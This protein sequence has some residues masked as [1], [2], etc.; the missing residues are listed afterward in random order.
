MSPTFTQAPLFRKRQA[1]L[2]KK[3]KPKIGK[4]TSLEK[5][6]RPQTIDCIYLQEL[7]AHIVAL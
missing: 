6:I 5:L 7:H 4:V 2:L 1:S 3:R